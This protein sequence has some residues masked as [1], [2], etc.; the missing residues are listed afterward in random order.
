M[1]ITHRQVE[2]FRAV[3]RT[4]TTVE[5]PLPL[6]TSQPSISRLIGELETA[7]RLKLFDRVKRRLLLTAEGSA[8]R[9]P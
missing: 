8:V 4:G 6:H 2:A 9:P 3:V 1:Q 7:V 5:A